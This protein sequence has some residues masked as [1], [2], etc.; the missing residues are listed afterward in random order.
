MYICNIQEKQPIIKGNLVPHCSILHPISWIPKCKRPPRSLSCLL[1]P[2][3]L[4]SSLTL[5]SHKTSK[6]SESWNPF[7]KILI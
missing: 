2:E 4:G 6:Y 7:P 3:Q 5:K 1:P